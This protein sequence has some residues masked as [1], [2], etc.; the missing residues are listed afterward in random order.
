MTQPRAMTQILRIWDRRVVLKYIQSWKTGMNSIMLLNRPCKPIQ[1]QT[2]DPCL[3]VFKIVE[4][5]IPGKVK[6]SCLDYHCSLYRDSSLRKRCAT[7]DEISCFA[8]VP[9]QVLYIDQY[10]GHVLQHYQVL[11]DYSRYD[12]TRSTMFCT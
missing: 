7:M 8:D 10:K 2:H 11:T 3:T 5:L 1:S 9:N 6:P 4:R 12:P